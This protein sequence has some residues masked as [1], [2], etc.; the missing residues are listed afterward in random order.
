MQL[1]FNTTLKVE[2][3]SCFEHEREGLI[4]E[5]RFL[6][7]VAVGVRP[8]LLLLEIVHLKELRMAFIKTNFIPY[9]ISDVVAS[10]FRVGGWVEM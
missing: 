9:R 8:S 5:C 7:Q 1:L 3:F 6:L 2:H 10:T 4:S